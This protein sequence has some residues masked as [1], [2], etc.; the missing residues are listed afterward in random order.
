MKYNFVYPV[1]FVVAFSCVK[2]AARP[3]N[4]S[5]QT[6]EAALDH[7]NL[8]TQTKVIGNDER[9]QLNQAELKTASGVGYFRIGNI[10][11]DNEFIGTGAVVFDRR[12]V[13]TAAHIFAKKGGEGWHNLIL[14]DGKPMINDIYYYVEACRRSY[15]VAALVRGTLDF[16]PEQDED[17]A[18]VRLGRPVCKAATPLPMKEIDM[19]FVKDN[20]MPP[21]KVKPGAP[22]SLRKSLLM[23]LPAFNWVGMQVMRRVAYG[24]SG[25]EYYDRYNL[26]IYHTADMDHGASGAPMII[27]WNNEDVIVGINSASVNDPKEPNTA[28][29][30]S[31]KILQWVKD[32]VDA[33]IIQKYPYR[34][35]TYRSTR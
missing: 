3:Y 5:S 30:I 6:S 10:P 19:E 22:A 24:Y 13:L 11:N 12:F 35:T 14:E 26:I 20:L 27:K 33:G 18:L 7:Q 23:M 29:A 1:L 16:K 25:G 8:F 34:Q 21:E 17:V 28:V 32:S 31:S 9:R 2:A 15:P 4:A